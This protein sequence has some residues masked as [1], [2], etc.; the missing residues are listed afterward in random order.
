MIINYKVPESLMA[1]RE[2]LQKFQKENKDIVHELIAS[3]GNIKRKE[4]PNKQQLVNKYFELVA[5]VDA[6]TRQACK[7]MLHN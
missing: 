5:Q 1:A 3:N 4:N 7:E 6:L 2:Q